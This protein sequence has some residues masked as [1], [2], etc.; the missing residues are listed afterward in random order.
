MSPTKEKAKARPD[1]DALADRI[2]AEL[3]EGGNVHAGNEPDEVYGL[4][5][6]NHP[7]HIG[8]QAADLFAKHRYSPAF[9]LI[10]EAAYKD[11]HAHGRGDA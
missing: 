8:R 11:G 4:L 2:A 7:A 9:Q 10:V 3:D 5:G 6:V 1:Y